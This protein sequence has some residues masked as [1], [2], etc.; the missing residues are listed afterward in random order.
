MKILNL[1]KE[2]NQEM[3]QEI[4]N[5]VDKCKLFSRENSG[6]SRVLQTLSSY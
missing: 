2:G 4:K 5:R 1:E 3:L 6:L